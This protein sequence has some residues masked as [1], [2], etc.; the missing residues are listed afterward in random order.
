M[1][2]LSRNLFRNQNDLIMERNTRDTDS[3]HLTIKCS[4]WLMRSPF[5]KLKGFR[6][7]EYEEMNFH[8]FYDSQFYFPIGDAD[9]IIPPIIPWTRTMST[10]P[11]PYQKKSESR[12]LTFEI[13]S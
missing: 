7:F 12:P 9:T 10:N 5:V 1:L 13:Y 2:I 3:Q 11:F 4:Y 6:S 8:S